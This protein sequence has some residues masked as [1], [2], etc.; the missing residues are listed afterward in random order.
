LLIGFESPNP[1][2]LDGM[3]PNNWKSRKAPEIEQI[4]DTLQSRGVSVNGC[5]ILGLDNHTPDTFP[6]L[7]ERVKRSGLAEVQYTVSTPF[8][9]TPLYQRL[10]REERL[11]PH[12]TWDDCTLFDVNFKPKNMS[13]S[14]LEAGLR[15][16]FTE[17][18]T[19]RETNRRKRSFVQQKRR[20]RQQ[21]RQ[22]ERQ[23]LETL[24]PSSEQGSQIVHLRLIDEAGDGVAVGDA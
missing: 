2:D 20:G 19:D 13:V 5:F 8:P 16:L 11:L 21:Q 17:T 9:G 6:A 3:D 4:V 14:D 24:G 7:H 1:S 15:W 23:R 10:E 22:G 18:Y 12:R